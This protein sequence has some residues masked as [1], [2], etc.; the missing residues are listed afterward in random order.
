MLKRVL[1]LLLVLLLTG[2]VYAADKKI[3]Q[4]PTETSPSGGD[5]LPVNVS[6]TTKKIT[7]TTLDTFYGITTHKNTATIHRSINDSGSGVTDL[8][9]ASKILTLLAAKADTS[10]S[11]AATDIT[12]GT[13]AIARGGT[14]LT[15]IASGKLLYAS[16]LD[17]LAELTLGSSLSIS[18]GTINVQNDTS[19]QKVDIS[20]NGSAIGSRKELNLIEG[21]GVTLTVS[22]NSGSNRVDVTVAA[23][24]SGL[25]R[26]EIGGL[27]ISNNVTDQGND[28]DIA[29]GAARDSTNAVDIILTSALTK[30]LDASWAVGTNQGGLDTGSKAT[31]TTYHVWLIKRSDTD[32][33]DV[34][35]STSAS[36]PTMPANYDFR[37]LIGSI[38]TDGSSN[39]LQFVQEGDYF[40]LKDPV[41]DVNVSNLGTT[42]TLYALST[43]SGL[44]TIALV[45][46]YFSNSNAGN[47]ACYISSPDQTDTAASSLYNVLDIGTGP[48]NIQMQILT[49]TSRQIRAR[50]DTAS[51]N[52]RIQ[53]RGWIH[54]RGR[55]D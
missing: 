39:I 33:E 15:G 18:T 10:H 25:P 45:D 36:S 12:S 11:H 21:S 52:L 19:T 16:A 42:A 23:G 43:P 26:G 40:L 6:G 8:F 1:S 5:E 29:V 37:R 50:A 17:T 3:S 35:F 55:F 49:D 53:T 2:S 4:L 32:V 41:V 38:R 27:E 14:G 47:N 31:S 30:R 44:K 13:L 46:G 22:D 9:S 28:I 48:G 20:K 24:T 7:L 51:S 54:N 34:L